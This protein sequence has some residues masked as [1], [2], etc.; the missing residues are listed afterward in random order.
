[1][2]EVSQILISTGEVSG[3]LQGS[4]LIEALQAAAAERGWPLEIQALGG[5]RMAQAGA[6]LIADTSRIGAIGVIE[7]LPYLGAALSVQRQVRRYLQTVAPQMVVL[8]DYV[9]FNL[10]LAGDIKRRYPG[11]PV[12]YYIAPQEWVWS[13]GTGTTRQIVERTDRILAI[14]PQEADYYRRHGATVDWV[15]HPFLDTLS[16]RPNRTEARQQLGIPPE[17]Q[18]IALMPAS[19]QQELRYIWPVLAEAAQRIQM[20]C[21]TVQFWIPVAQAGFRQTLQH[22]IQTLGLRATLC[23]RPQWVL[24]A[25]DLVLGKSGTANLEAALRLVPQI[26]VYRIHPI[27]GWLYRKLLRFKVPFISP[28]N[29]I[30]QT[31]VVPE[32]L[33]EAATPAAIAA[34]ALDLLQP[35]AARTRMLQQY[36]QLRDSLGTPGAA[37]RAAEAILT[38]LS[39]YRRQSSFR[40]D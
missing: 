9:G 32:L 3:D 30:C 5:P 20:Q 16:R 8:I 13:F 37:Q 10:W 19:R 12:V 33:Q 21:P 35:S 6:T 4:L 7:S 17:Q 34:L 25:A 27:N 15:G 36:G 39:A 38:S 18:A 24:T 11:C 1:M 23:D 28:V 26:A 31:A 40:C 14:F 2:T 29:L 22:T